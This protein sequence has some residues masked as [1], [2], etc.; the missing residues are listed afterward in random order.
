MS[1][2]SAAEKVVTPASVA[3]PRSRWWTGVV[4]TA[5][6]LVLA[7]VVGAVVMVLADPDVVGKFAYFFS[8]PG[9]ALSASWDKITLAYG[10]LLRGSLGSW[11]AITETTAQATPLICAGLGV[12]LAFRAGL[13]NIGGQGQAIWGAIV[14]AWIGFSVTGLP[15]IL[16]IP[17]ALICAMVFGA[18]WGGIAGFLKAKAGA[19][20]VITT[21]MLNHI[22]STMLSY[23]LIT[24][25]F[26]MPGRTDPISPVIEWTATLPRIA[27]TRLHLGFLLALLAAVAVWW[28]LERTTL[29]FQIRAVG[30]NPYAAGTAGMSVAR[31]TIVAMAIAGGLAGLAGAQMVMAP[32][33]LTSFPPQLSAGIVGGVGFDAITVALLGR[34]RPL[35][36]VVAGLLFGAMKAGGLTMS[37][38]AQ[39]PSELTSLIQAL[40]VLFVAAPKFVTWL[41]PA[42]RERR[43]PRVSRNKKAVAA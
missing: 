2:E 23:L 19:H 43:A 25:M 39:T 15:M 17:L 10:A 22:A 38:E 36:V 27:G 34:S 20:E 24:S 16:H 12:A 6:A 1:E 9:D 33:L 7:F 18:I 5:I 26:Q 41:V 11:V 21:I 29:G 8:R 35:G 14:G 13:F 31:V 42:L 3:A 30:H 28:L 37:A 40:I 32:T 4:V